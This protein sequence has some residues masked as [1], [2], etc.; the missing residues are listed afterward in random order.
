MMRRLS[1]ALPEVETRIAGAR[2]LLLGLDF[3]GTLVP[4]VDVPTMSHLGP[5]AARVLESLSK[6]DRVSVVVMSGRERNDL[7]TRVGIPSIIYAGNHGLEIGG[8][9]FLFVDETAAA[10]GT[11]LRELGANLATRLMPIPGAL[12]EDKGLTVAV[13]ERLVAED[14]REEVRRIVH[15]VLAGSSHPF[16]LTVGQRVYEIR[17]RTSW[18]RGSAITWIRERLGKPETL[19]IYLG[20]DATDEDAFAALP[21]DITIR[22]GEAAETAAHFQ[23]DN[24]AEVH[25]FLEWVETRLRVRR[26]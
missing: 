23:I 21:D 11:A 20:D 1:D 15:G 2:H 17:P 12:V 24:P 19:T 13:H 26:G 18:H 8:P 16:Q 5:A 10:H 25:G 3:E 6:C 4:F 22:V 9:G 14:A 7:Q